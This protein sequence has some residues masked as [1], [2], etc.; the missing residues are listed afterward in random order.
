M[1]E[2]CLRL[3]KLARHLSVFAFPGVRCRPSAPVQSLVH[4]PGRLRFSR[5]AVSSRRYS[6]RIARSFTFRTVE[7]YPSRAQL[8]FGLLLLPRR[9]R[10]FLKPAQVPLRLTYGGPSTSRFFGLQCRHLLAGRTQL[11]LRVRQILPRSVEIGLGPLPFHPGRPRVHVRF[12]TSSRNSGRFSV[13]LSASSTFDRSSVIRFSR[14][15]RTSRF[16]PISRS[17]VLRSVLAC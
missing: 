16:C 1:S 11:P 17:S 15:S 13:S 8:R 14:L 2:T 4:A 3:R 5:F 12:F 6:S 7:G 9:F 10:S